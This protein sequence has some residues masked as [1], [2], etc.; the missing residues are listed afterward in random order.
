MA[1]PPRPLT[2]GRTVRPGSGSPSG[3]L[4][5]GGLRQSPCPEAGAESLPAAE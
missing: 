3:Q 1:H 5:R 2:E 4:V